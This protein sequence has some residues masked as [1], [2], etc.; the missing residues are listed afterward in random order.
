MKRQIRPDFPL[1]FVFSPWGMPYTARMRKVLLPAMLTSVAT[2]ATA[3]ALY[4]CADESGQVLYTNQKTL[5]KN[6]TLLSRDQAVS[7]FNAPKAQPKTPTPS[8]FPRVGG[9]QQ[10]ARDGDRRAILEQELAAEQKNLEDAKRALLGQEGQILPNERNA[11]G[12]INGAKVQERL[13][14]YQ[15][16]VQLHE[17]NIEALRK[18]LAN[19]R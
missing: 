16:K 17:R 15:D 3:D 13:K 10:K 18:E 5:G 12:G 2:T 7:T 6:C 11:G 9:D 8:D 19:L 1:V 4:K 14:T